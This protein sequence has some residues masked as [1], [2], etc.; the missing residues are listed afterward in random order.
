MDILW[1]QR[2][3]RKNREKGILGIEGSKSS[4]IETVDP[5]RGG[6]MESKLP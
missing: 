5:A 2:L 3:Q 1:N 4:K 6:A